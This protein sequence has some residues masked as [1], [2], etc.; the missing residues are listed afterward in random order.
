MNPNPNA[1]A[2]WSLL[3]SPALASSLQMPAARI[4]GVLRLAERAP[5][6]LV[7]PARA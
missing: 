5:V 6:E 7:C 4:G 2:S 1:A 3:F